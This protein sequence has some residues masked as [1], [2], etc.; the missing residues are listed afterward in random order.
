M[1][2]QKGSE[3]GERV[4]LHFRWRKKQWPPA[5]CLP[6]LTK[7]QGR[8]EGG[9]SCEARSEGGRAEVPG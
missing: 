1:A 6:G 8:G 7:E 5:Q 3:G 2:F 9:W 4:N